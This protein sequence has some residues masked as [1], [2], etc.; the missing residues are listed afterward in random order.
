MS[1]PDVQF[2]SFIKNKKYLEK[3]GTTWY[4]VIRNNGDSGDIL[5]K[6]LKDKNGNDISD[7]DVGIMA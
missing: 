1:I 7:I 2:A 4:I 3:V 6:A 5:R